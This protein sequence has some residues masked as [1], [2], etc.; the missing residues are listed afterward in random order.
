MNRPVFHNSLSLLLLAAVVMIALFYRLGEV[1]LF[2]ED[3]GA[4]AE[5]T[6]EMLRS[7][8]FITPRL[9][10]KPFFHKPPILYWAQA[11][12][13]S[14]L[15][16]TETAFRLPSVLAA[17]AWLLLLFVFVRRQMDQETAAFAVFFMVSALQVN[18]VIRAAIADTLLNLFITMTMFAIFAYSQTPGKRYI[19]AAFAGMALGFMTK[20]PIAIAI[21]V[22]V[23]LLFFLCQGDLKTWLRGACSP[24]G[25]GVF[26]IIALPW[27]VVLCYRFGW[28]FVQE[29]F[30]VQNIGRFRSAME[31]H[32][33][34]FFYYVPVILLG[35]LPFT[36]ILIR[37]FSH[38]G[39]QIKSPWTRF[40]WIWFGF[41]F[42]FFSVADTKLQHYIIYGYVP[43]LI[44]MGQSV[45]KLKNPWLLALPAA[46]FLLPV[47]FLQKVAIWMLP[48][49]GNHFARIV[50]Q[51][52]LGNVGTTHQIIV[53]LVLAGVIMV[54]AI[55][56]VSMQWRSLVLGC[57]FTALITGHLAPLAAD[58][59]QVPVKT[60]ALMAKARNYDVIM[61]QMNYPSFNVYYG[62]PAL[63]KK[64]L[65]PGDII[66][67]KTDKLSRIKD[68]EIIYQKHGIVLSRIR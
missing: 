8:D 40:L 61:W 43:L 62:K 2:D 21:P 34:P 54:A 67:T 14:V 30:M 26:L 20:G 18:L 33:G 37:A 66:I 32:S 65:A 52:A 9:E 28:H 29:L 25:W 35:L 22:V 19:I 39:E 56:R 47:L 63:Q 51:S 11:A 1:P 64:V 5:V 44:F 41:V 13:V 45:G 27:Y 68:Y 42:V 36:T 58:I 55:P 31:G 3:E 4:Y 57:L 24:L 23:S 6:L 16:P 46:L 50:V 15:G 17:A 7:G 12:S 53:G 59:M 48:R 49:I 10:G 38:I 60:A